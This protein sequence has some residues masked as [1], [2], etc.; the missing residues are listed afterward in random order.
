MKRSI[1]TLF[2]LI[3]VLIFSS[4]IKNYYVFERYKSHGINEQMLLD[5]KTHTYILQDYSDNNCIMN[6][7]YGSFKLEHD[8]ITVNSEDLKENEYNSIVLTQSNSQINDSTCIII[9]DQYCNSLFYPSIVFK[10]VDSYTDTLFTHLNN[11]K[12]VKHKSDSL[13]VLWNFT[14]SKFAGYNYL[15]DTINIQLISQFN[16][17]NRMYFQKLNTEKWTFKDGDLV[18]VDTCSSLKFYKTRYG[19]EDKFKKLKRDKKSNSKNQLIKLR[20]ST[21]SPCRIIKTCALPLF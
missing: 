6:I 15:S 16:R 8:T 17:Y 13:S 19:F 2:I 14:Q 5:F 9:Y 3:A 21:C 4:C 1:K 11:F 20:D 18:Y 12:I 7:S 10:T